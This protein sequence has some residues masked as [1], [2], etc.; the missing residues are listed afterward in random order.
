LLVAIAEGKVKEVASAIQTR[1]A[2]MARAAAPSGGASPP[3]G[4]KSRRLRLADL[5][6]RAVI[7][8]AS[9]W[10]EVDAAVRRELAAGN[11]VELG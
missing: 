6:R 7:A 3:T 4:G 10:E 8:S 5:G 1:K 2:E 9:E 11:E